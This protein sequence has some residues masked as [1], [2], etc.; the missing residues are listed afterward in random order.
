MLFWYVQQ[1]GGKDPLS[2][3]EFKEVTE[4]DV[5]IECGEMNALLADSAVLERRF[6]RSQTRQDES[7]M[8]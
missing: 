7:G 6:E 5:S 8:N 2:A 4:T 1:S 3:V